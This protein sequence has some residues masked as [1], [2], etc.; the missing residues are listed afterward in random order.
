VSPETDHVLVEVAGLDPTEPTT[1]SF[2]LEQ[3]GLSALVGFYEYE[4]R[5][6]VLKVPKTEEVRR[7]ALGDQP[8]REPR[9]VKVVR[10]ASARWNSLA[11]RPSLWPT[12][13]RFNMMCQQWLG[14]LQRDTAEKAL[15]RVDGANAATV[16]GLAEE[17]FEHRR[18]LSFAPHISDTVR[19]TFRKGPE[20]VFAM[21]QEN[22]GPAH[23]PAT[24]FSRPIRRRYLAPGARLRELEFLTLVVYARHLADTHGLG[25]DLAPHIASGGFSVPN[26]LVRSDTGGLVYVDYF[27]LAQRDGNAIEAGA[28][29]AMYGRWGAARRLSAWVY[30][31]LTG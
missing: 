24:P 3:R 9:F 16:A 25:L 27:G 28:F 22:V 26:V 21:V 18:E 15:R 12:L 31:G 17:L 30:R 10:R 14:S 4:D 6:Y 5:A 13:E 29:G 8:V 11:P 1:V 19:I 23:A 2:P 7:W 20:D